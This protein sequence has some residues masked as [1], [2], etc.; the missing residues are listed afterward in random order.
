[1]TF[2]QINELLGI[3][4][5]YEMPEKLLNILLNGNTEELFDKFMECSNDLSQDL[6]NEYFQTEHGDR[7]K[8][9]QD[10]TP[11]SV[12]HIVSEL[13]GEGNNTADI[14]SGTGTLTIKQWNN[15]HSKDKFYHLEEF[16]SRAIPILLFNIAIRG[17]NA[18]VIHCDVLSREVFAVYLVEN[19]GKYSKIKKLKKQQEPR[20]YD[21]VIMNPPYS[22]KWSGQDDERFTGYGVAPKSKGDYAFILHG[23]NMLSDNG[24]LIAILPHG[25]LFRGASE[26]QI[27][28]KL[29]EN[30]LLDKIIGLPPNLFLNTGIPVAILV[31][32]KNRKDKKVLFVDASKEF[33]KERAYNILKQEHINKILNTCKNN[34]EI[35]KYSS[36]IDFEEIKEND[37]NLNIPRYVDTTEVEVL[38]PLENLFM[39]L[40]EIDKN[41]NTT[42]KE[43]YKMFQ[44]LVGTTEEKEIKLGEQ[45][46]LFGEY[47]KIREDVFNETSK[48]M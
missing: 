27:R 30:N 34:W 6:F 37:F 33:E 32:K 11:Q 28:Q 35:K 43:L 5:S 36:L 25:V 46:A 2:T 48:I 9:K 8:L 19:N 13:T 14:C 17:M 40:I 38:E 18:E 39:D 45:R 22:V 21:N 26:G 31:L 23:L 3:K 7:D 1:M 44:E 42:E 4:E 16:S 20:K 15:K 47:L 29:I 41:I 24:T 12:A 10:F